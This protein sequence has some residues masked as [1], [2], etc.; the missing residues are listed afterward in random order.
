MPVT[1]SATTSLGIGIALVV[2]SPSWP[3][4]LSPHVNT[5][6]WSLQATQWSDPATKQQLAWHI[7][8]HRCSLSP[9]SLPQIFPTKLSLANSLF[10]PYSH[11]SKILAQL[12]IPTKILL[13]WLSSIRKK[14]TYT[15]CCDHSATAHV[16]L[17]NTQGKSAPTHAAVIIPQQRTY[18]Y[19]I[20][21]SAPTHAA[22]IIP[23]Q[24]TY[25]YITHK[26]KVHLH[27]L[28]WS[29]HTTTRT[30]T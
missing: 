2:P 11:G 1:C 20:H 21:K 18:H 28:L 29:L 25:H 10:S 26:A 8:C 5:S 4:S 13:A 14:C 17:H 12:T 15:C 16:P 24:C 30:I 9:G 23:Q 27:M 7:I 6:P 3:S 19:I 22:V